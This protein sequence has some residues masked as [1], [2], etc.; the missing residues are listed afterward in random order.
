MRKLDRWV[1]GVRRSEGRIQPLHSTQ[2]QEESVVANREAGAEGRIPDVSLSFLAFRAIGR[3]FVSRSGKEIR[4]RRIEWL[5]RLARRYSDHRHV[6]VAR[7]AFTVVVVSALAI[8]HD[9]TFLV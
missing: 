7:R 2:I 6:Y 8:V 4:I 3:H 1:L 5:P 9:H